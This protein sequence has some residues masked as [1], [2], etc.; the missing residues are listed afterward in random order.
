VAAP[1]Y[2]LPGP[3]ERRSMA[4]HTQAGTKYSPQPSN[5]ATVLAEWVLDADDD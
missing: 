4:I 2:R 1:L 3:S 5:R